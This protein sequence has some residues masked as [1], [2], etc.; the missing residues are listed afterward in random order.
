MRRLNMRKSPSLAFLAVA[1]IVLAG[2]S[3]FGLSGEEILAKVEQ[4]LTGPKDYEGTSVMMLAN[5]DGT[6]KEQRSLK[7]W[8][9]GGEKRVIKFTSPAGIEGIGLL[10]EGPGE[11][12]LYLPSQNKIRRIEGGSMNEDFQGTDFSYNEMGSF[13]Y[14]KDYAAELKAEDEAA[15]TLSL[16]KKAG[17]DRIYDELVMVVG[18]SDYVPQRIEMYAKGRML[19]ILTILEVTKSGS[20]QVP[21]RLRMENLDKKHYTEMTMSSLKFDQ[22]LEAK[23]VFSKRFLKKKA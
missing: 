19:K 11:M 8:I 14:K 1:F 13:D 23:D 22:G 12:Y 20:Y 5:S 3:A 9:A 17:A 6:G 7:V 10:T 16:A 15:W 18:K 21:A 4:T 2:G